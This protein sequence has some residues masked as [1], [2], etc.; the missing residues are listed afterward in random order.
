MTAV[1]AAGGPLEL[2]T[3]RNRRTIVRRWPVLLL[4][5]LV[6]AGCGGAEVAGT[7][8]GGDPASGALVD[9]VDSISARGHD[10]EVTCAQL[11]DDQLGEAVSLDTAD[12]RFAAAKTIRGEDADTVLA[13]ETTGTVAQCPDA[14]HLL[15]IA[16]SNAS[17]PASAAERGRRRCYVPAIPA[18]PQCDEG[19]PFWFGT[20]PSE[21]GTEGDGRTGV[22]IDGR[23]PEPDWRQDPLEVTAREIGVS[24]DVPA[25]YKLR[26]IGLRFI[27]QTGDKIVVEAVHENVIDNNGS[28]YGTLQRERHTLRRLPGRTGWY[29][30]EFIVAEYGQEDLD[31]AALDAAW[32]GIDR[33]VVDV[34]RR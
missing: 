2:P 20:D 15:A 29:P 22:W 19:G 32:V 7:G 33:A 11:G 12:E 16:F 18:E 23:I 13:L 34:D 3:D 8:R 27:E 14:T 10:Y 30:T 6:T 25:F 26:R 21:D 4:A 5:V 24:G 17:D 28:P 31:D 1:I 9:R